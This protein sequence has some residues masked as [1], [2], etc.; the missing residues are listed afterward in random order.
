[1]ATRYLTLAVVGVQAPA[2]AQKIA[3]H[4]DRF[5]AFFIESYGCERISTFLRRDVLA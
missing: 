1:V 5:V 4:L 3:L 2:V